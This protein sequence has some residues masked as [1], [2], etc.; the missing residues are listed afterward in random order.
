MTDQIEISQSQEVMDERMTS[1]LRMKVE[2]M[3]MYHDGFSF[4][5]ETELE[6]YKAAYAYRRSKTTKVRFAPNINQWLVQVYN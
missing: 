2:N 5:V 3:S 6:A 1:H 4:T